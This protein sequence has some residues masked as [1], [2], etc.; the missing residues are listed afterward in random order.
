MRRCLFVGLCCVGVGCS[1]G[2][3]KETPTSIKSDSKPE[4]RYVIVEIEGKRWLATPGS[5]G[6]W[7]LAGPLE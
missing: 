2:K 3:L 7:S 6:E 4:I 1:D 5:H